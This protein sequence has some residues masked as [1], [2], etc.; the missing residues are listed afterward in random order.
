MK[1]VTYVESINEINQIEDTNVE[2]IFGCKELSRL[3]K[4]SVHELNHFKEAVKSK[5]LDL[6][7]EWD[8]LMT[9]SD[10]EIRL[11]EFQEIDLNGVKA[12][13]LQDPGAINYV[14]ENTDIPIQI[15]LENGNHNFEAIE[16]WVSFL[17]KRLDRVVLSIELPKE[18]IKEYCTKLKC[19][20]EFY[21]LGQILI[22]YTPRNLLS[23]I[24]KE[25]EDS[26]TKGVNNN[27]LM[28]SGESEES[29]HKG[30]PLVENR[31][32]TFMFHVKDQCLLEHIDELKSFGLS[33]FRIDLRRTDKNSLLI[34]IQNLIKDFDITKAKEIKS[35]YGN[36]V[37]KG[38]Y[39]VNKSDVLFP[40]L[41]N[42]RL[43][44]REGDFI[45]NVVEVSKDKYI[46]ID[47]KNNF[48]SKEMSQLKIETP[49]GKEKIIELKWIKDINLNEVNILEK[50][51]LAVVKYFSGVVPMSA[52]YRE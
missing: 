35:S 17:G 46:V 2:L 47:I 29:P 8:I 6:V 5:K 19:D 52:V 18:K 25:H 34:P 10:F 24:Y 48:I 49:E 22:F 12:I 36:D 38:Y 42:Y 28:A 41:K 30:F 27:F 32:G 16:Q 15:I 13:R 7:F 43:Q 33:H 45:G 23:P 31:H 20:I 11:K 39:N 1:L 14:L 40:K 51:S 9:Q 44:K 26:I 50:G 21:G 37:I 4:C 3:G